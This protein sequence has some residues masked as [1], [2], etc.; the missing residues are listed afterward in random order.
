MISLVYPLL[1]ISALVWLAMAAAML[2]LAWKI[3]MA[4]KTAEDGLEGANE[5]R[6]VQVPKRGRLTDYRSIPAEMV[7]DE[8]G[9]ANELADREFST[10]I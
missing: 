8:T 10:Y 9:E 7:V 2:W 3:W 1:A 4:N 5:V 6:M